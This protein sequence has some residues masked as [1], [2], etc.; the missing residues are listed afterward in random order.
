MADN[1]PNPAMNKLLSSKKPDKA[2]AKYV[3]DAAKQGPA[4]DQIRT[5]AEQRVAGKLMHLMRPGQH[6]GD[7]TWTPPVVEAPREPR[8][9]DRRDY[10]NEAAAN[11]QFNAARAGNPREFVDPNFPGVDR[12]RFEQTGES[13]PRNWLGETGATYINAASAIPQLR[14]LLG[15]NPV[16]EKTN[17]GYPPKRKPLVPYKSPKLPPGK[18]PGGDV[19]VPPPPAPT[20]TPVPLPSP[21]PSPYAG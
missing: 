20:P 7:T 6:G 13:S 18:G 2:S 3:Q 5:S 21:E 16:D 14:A 9:T 8:P 19:P 15:L 12:N 4:G 17:P 11:S 1:K 10:P